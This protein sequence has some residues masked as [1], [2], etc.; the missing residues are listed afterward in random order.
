MH[1]RGDD[2]G[3]VPSGRSSGNARSAGGP[4]SFFPVRSDFTEGYIVIHTLRKMAVK[5][6]CAVAGTALLAL[7]PATAHAATADRSGGSSPHVAVA[8]SYRV[9]AAVTHDVADAMTPNGVGVGGTLAPGVS[10]T[11]TYQCPEFFCNWG[12][13]YAGNDIASV[14]LA[15]VDSGSW[16]LTLDHADNISGFIPIAYMHPGGAVPNCTSIPAG[17]LIGTGLVYQCPEFYC[18]SGTDYDQNPIVTFCNL[19][20]DAG[21][22]TLTLDLADMVEGFLPGYFANSGC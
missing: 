22:W 19:Q 13:D 1:G 14:C 18:N 12:T 2:T 17:T 16:Y 21:H 7:L 3:R 11:K 4:Q 20:S 5:A 15:S 8:T 6:A 10:S 9:A